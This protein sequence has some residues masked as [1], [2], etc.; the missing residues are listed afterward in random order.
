MRLPLF[1]K[2]F[3]T[4]REESSQFLEILI[5]LLNKI[6]QEEKNKKIR[7]PIWDDHL[8]PDLQHYLTS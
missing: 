7:I 3:I 8:S 6:F 2:Y 4:Y 5:L 1:T